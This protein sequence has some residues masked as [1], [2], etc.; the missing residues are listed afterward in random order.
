MNMKNI[1][2]CCII[3]LCTSTFAQNVGIGTSNPQNKLDVNGGLSVGSLYS[4]VNAAPANGAI[5]QGYV[6]IG[7][8]QPVNGL[9]IHE[10]D[11]VFPTNGEGLQITSFSFGATNTDGFTIRLSPT[12]AE[13][14][15]LNYENAA[16]IFGTNGNDRMYLSPNGFLG[17]GTP[18]PDNYLHIFDDRGIMPVIKISTTSAT[19]GGKLSLETSPSPKLE[20]SNDEAN[21]I[22]RLKNAA[23]AQF[24]LTATGGVNTTIA[25]GQDFKINTDF[26]VD[27]DGKTVT[28]EF[29]M[30]N[31]ADLN[32]IL[33]SDASGNAT[34]VNG[35][36]TVKARNGTN[37]NTDDP[38]DPYI[39]L[40]GP[41]VRSTSVD[42]GANTLDF[43]AVTVNAFSVDGTTFSV[44]AAND[45]VGIGTAA[46]TNK[47]D[48][49]GSIRL[50]ET[51]YNLAGASPSQ[52]IA[53]DVSQARLSGAPTGTIALTTTS[54]Q[55]GQR[56][57]VYNG[58]T[59]P[60]TLASKTINAGE[61]VEFV[62]SNTAWRSIADGSL[63]DWST[64]GNAGTTVGGNFIGTTDA[65]N[66]KF[67]V[68]N[69]FS[70]LIEHDGT[71]QTHF[72]YLAGAASTA[73]YNT[74]F[75]W[76]AL[77]ATTSGTGSNSAFGLQALN[78]NTTGYFN[79]A[80]GGNAAALNQNGFSN[81]AIGYYALISNVS[82]TDNAALGVQTLF[83]T[84]GLVDGL[85]GSKNT[86]FGSNAGYSITTGNDNVAL[87]YYAMNIGTTHAIT[88]SRN[89]AI[90]VYA[91]NITPEAPSSAS[92]NTFIGYLANTTLATLTNST[93]IGSNAQVTTSNSM[94]LGSINGVN[95]AVA[96]TN[97]GIGTTAPSH[98]LHILETGN[99][100]AVSGLYVNE[101]NAGQAVTI[102]EA[103]GGQALYIIES[104]GGN[105]I[106]ITANDAGGAINSTAQGAVT[107][108]V[109]GHDFYDIRTSSTDA[110]SKIGARISSTGTWNGTG[111]TNTGLDV[112]VSGGT[113]NYSALFNGGNVGIGTTNPSYRLDVDDNA[114]VR[115]T[116]EVR[117][118]TASTGY[119]QL[120]AGNA[121]QAGY[122]AWFK[123]DGNR[124]AY[125]G[126]DNA[127]LN[128]ALENSSNFYIT[129]GNV[130]V[131]AAA[132][133]THRLDVAEA[134]NNTWG[135]RITQSNATNS[136]GLSVQTRTAAAGDWAL[137]VTSNN[138]ATNCLAVRNNGRVGI[139]LA[140]PGFPLE[141]S[142][143]VN[144]SLG[145]YIHIAGTSTTAWQNPAA[146][147]RAV[148]IKANG[149]IWATGGFQSSSD[150]RAKENISSI[151]SSESIEIINKLNPVNYNWIDRVKSGNSIQSGF[152]A[153]EVEQIFPQAVTKAKDFLP[154][155][156]ALADNYSIT[157][158]ALH[159]SMSKEY[160]LQKGDLVKFHTED[161]KEHRLN[162]ID[163]KGTQYSFTLTEEAKSIYGKLFVYGK[164]VEDFNTVDYD[165]IFTIGISAIQELSKKVDALEKENASLKSE[166]TEIMKSL[167]AQIDII[168][169]RL[170]IK[171]EK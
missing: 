117:S 72:G 135:A 12:T 105:G 133:T 134:G 162:V 81:T 80:M 106:L 114:R 161:G 126:W 107:A 19:Q 146:A 20:L 46:P 60:A 7:T 48:I 27:A 61:A 157:N 42:Q 139:G 97:V 82:G 144:A 116:I 120:Q 26:S 17:I 35:T 18:T 77:A 49:N 64:T 43:T 16:M 69:N 92:N 128:L 41:L 151:T 2:L 32:K 62:Y 129:G 115:S 95:G 65:N 121:A 141:V 150:R 132:S 98:V 52:A 15:L 31:G 55:D 40:G 140:A 38:A 4:G 24:D 153:Q 85:Q 70:G 109:V 136:N 75:G 83:R 87:G 138:G 147:N 90:G 23:G 71:L 56:L 66:L 13:T 93:A 102:E 30:T 73:N 50:R 8:T 34:W 156:Y 84:A 37:I 124:Q 53:A 104:N 167:K 166:N 29:Q 127:N 112:T 91:G 96:S 170:S 108:A 118:A 89:V 94:V 22:L 122:A 155:V 111:S 5:I 154:N 78:A 125:M 168:N 137:Q 36:T 68:N 25:A 164:E 47:L 51:N 130:G 149:Y 1:I 159:I 67:K 163:A 28:R 54:P 145:G 57:V 143:T 11:A 152:I 63:D 76:Q 10:S 119:I 44:D 9:H 3:L 165:R 171:T 79:T 103:G 99:D 110:I 6:G 131:G 45:F 169:E 88:G 148:S 86:G 100:G 123:T 59:I 101:S 74:S 142:G 58:T 39:E 113:T 33:R 14:R 160:D 158:E 21:A